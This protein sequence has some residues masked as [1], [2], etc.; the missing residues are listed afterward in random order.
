MAVGNNLGKGLVQEVPLGSVPYPDRT[1]PECTAVVHLPYGCN[2]ARI[3]REGSAGN[4]IW[5]IPVVSN[6]MNESENSTQAYRRPDN[7]SNL[8]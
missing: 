3:G 1:V 7:K 8:V 6:R 4:S 5:E 2:Y